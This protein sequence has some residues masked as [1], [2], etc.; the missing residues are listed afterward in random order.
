[1]KI[2]NFFVLFSEEIRKEIENVFDDVSEEFS[3][4]RNV[5]KIFEQW[6]FNETDS[7]ND[8][9][10]EICLPKVFS[11]IIRKEIVEWNPIEVKLFS[12]LKQT[13]RNSFFV[14]F[15]F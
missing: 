4:C 5:K 12:T 2:S 15:F 8:A 3:Q 6:K 10:I 13:K 14:W 7:Y 11:P 9:F 1:M